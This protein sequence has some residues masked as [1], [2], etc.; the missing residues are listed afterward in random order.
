MKDL[1][2]RDRDAAALE[3]A[4]DELVLPGVGVLLVEIDLH[5]GVVCAGARHDD[6]DGIGGSDGG[7][8]RLPN[9]GTTAL[10]YYTGCVVGEIHEEMVTTND[11]L[12]NVEQRLARGEH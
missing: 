4:V 1:A 8:D 5:D 9:G 2:A 11:V 3:A 12:T 10:R 7:L 6:G